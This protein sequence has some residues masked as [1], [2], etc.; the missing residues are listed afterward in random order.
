MSGQPD[1]IK[2]IEGFI[3]EYPI[4][5]FHFLTPE[6][7]VFSDKVR[8][9]CREDCPHYGKSWACPP[10]IRPVEDCIEACRA[11]SHVFL[12]TS[13]AQVPDVMNFDACLEAR[14]DH[15]RMTREIKGCFESRFGKV[16]ALSTG[17][18]LCDTCAYPDGP[19]R[20]PEERLST[21]ESHGIL[22]METASCLGVTMDCG[23]D[24]VV[25]ISLIFFN[26]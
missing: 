26:A 23:N 9:I 16:L 25:Y 3:Y 4:C 2:I 13:V 1:F 24:A 15:E 21:I 22:I 20:H 10:A 14:R 17:C 8:V 19:C 5:E 12:F 6:E 18:M 11:F 7:L